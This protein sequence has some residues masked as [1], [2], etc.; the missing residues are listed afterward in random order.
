MKSMTGFGTSNKK[1]MSTEINVTLKCVN[2]RFLEIR[3]SIPTEYDPYELKI[4]KI[5]GEIIKRGTVG[6]SIKRA[7]RD[8]D[9]FKIKTATDILKNLEYLKKKLKLKTEITLDHILRFPEV[10]SSTEKSEVLKEEEKSLYIAV[11]EAA[12]KCDQERVREGN[13]LR[14]EIKTHLE[15]LIEKTERIAKNSLLRESDFSERYS[16]RLKKFDSKIEIDPA[17][18]AQE[19]II[20]LDKMDISEEV[21][22]VGEHLNAL[23]NILDTSESTGKKLEFY[24]QELFREFNTIGSKSQIPEITNT[25]VD[26]KLIIERIREQVQNIE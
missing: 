8:K 7:A 13:A 22:R 25:V 20:L 24:T 21:A 16:K 12:K 4:K 26:C 14:E 3:P 23:L 15:L 17:R 11:K 18:I 5:I 10:I 6:V 19:I 9:S 2:G 1:S